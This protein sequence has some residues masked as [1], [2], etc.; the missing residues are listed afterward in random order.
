MLGDRALPSSLKLKQ[1]SKG[2]PQGSSE[3]CKA[4]QWTY[5]DT[6]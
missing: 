1:F 3:V 4:S 5:N 2:E 6:V